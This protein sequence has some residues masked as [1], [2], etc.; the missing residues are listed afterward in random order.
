MNIETMMAREDYYPV[1]QETIGRYFRKVKNLEVTVSLSEIPGGLPLRSSL[2]PLC[3]STFPLNAGMKKFLYAEYNIRK[4]KLKYLAAKLGVFFFTLSRQVFLDKTIY[5]SGL[6]ANEQDLFICPCNRTI[7]F[8]DFKKNVVDC[9]V[10][11]GRRNDF[12]KNQVEFRKNHC[13][14]FIPEV[15]EVGD[16]WYREKI[17]HGHALA[18]VTDSQIYSRSEIQ[19]VECIGRLIKDTASMIGIDDYWAELH[20]SF[21]LIENRLSNECGDGLKIFEEIFSDFKNIFHDRKLRIPVAVSHGDLQRGNIWVDDNGKILIYDWETAGNRSVWF[22]LMVFWCDMHKSAFCTDI[23]KS[24]QENQK[25]F[26]FDTEPRSA[27]DL[28]I[29]SGIILLE[30]MLFQLSEITQLETDFQ[31]VR[32]SE[33]A[34]ALKNYMERT[35]STWF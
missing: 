35:V 7:R 32:L 30:E 26:R 28:S 23:L 20:K 8:Y 16:D 5:I 14:S 1:I 10:K 34:K 29:I 25:L 9:I 12:M 15:V 19:A 27:D 33:A 6:P 21:S 22:D 18:R 13:H 4:N 3:I 2:R 11:T 17:M 24:L 31:H